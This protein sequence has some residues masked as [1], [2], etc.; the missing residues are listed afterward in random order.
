MKK[1]M[2]FVL[3]FFTTLFLTGCNLFQDLE[4]TVTLLDKS[5]YSDLTIKGTASIEVPETLIANEV[6]ARV[7]EQAKNINYHIS[8]KNTP[9]VNYVDAEI[10]M[11]GT[12]YNFKAYTDEKESLMYNGTGWYFFEEKPNIQ[13][14]AFVL[15]DIIKEATLLEK[16][17]FATDKQNI[18]FN[19]ETVKT[20]IYQ[21]NLSESTLKRLGELNKLD[22][23]EVK[24]T[25]F[26]EKN[27]PRVIQYETKFSKKSDFGDSIKVSAEGQIL[28]SSID[29]G[30]VNPPEPTVNKTYRT[31]E[32]F[33]I[34]L[35]LK[36][37]L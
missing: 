21:A 9:T 11:G 12:N 3:L 17:N 15:T 32:D 33:L 6:E 28:I 26:A 23:S 20:K 14:D 13:L 7:I 25:I 1:T 8:Q 22:F 2:S 30:T 35:L 4:K 18:T 5:V 16:D 24:L 31:I 29:E 10:S 37:S 27:K 36:D 34:E 19:G